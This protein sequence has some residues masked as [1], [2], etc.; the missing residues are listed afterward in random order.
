MSSSCSRTDEI[1]FDFLQTHSGGDGLGKITVKFYT[2]DAKVFT[3]SFPSF[4]NVAFIKRTL[5][6]LFKC[7]RDVIDLLYRE[8]HIPEQVRILYTGD[9]SISATIVEKL[10]PGQLIITRNFGNIFFLQ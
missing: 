2:T 10:Y 4:Y 7:P 6:D 3:Q 1:N 9:S 8:E 5:L